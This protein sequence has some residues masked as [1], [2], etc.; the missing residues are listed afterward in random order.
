MIQI[1][2]NH[3][4]HLF[5]YL[6]FYLYFY[7][8][9]RSLNIILLNFFKIEKM[10]ENILFIKSSIFYPILG[11]FFTGNLLILIN[12]FIP[13]KSFIVVILLI[14]TLIPNI[15]RFEKN[16]FSVSIENFIMYLIIPFILIM[17]LYNTG[18][19]YDAGFYHLNHQNWL[20][21][22]Q[23]VI[24]FINVHWA[25][26]MSSIYE[27]LSSILWFDISFKYLHFLN[28]LFIH[29]FYISLF[30][31]I[32]YSKEKILKNGAFFLLLFSLLDNI[33]MN[34][35]RNGFIYI[36][37]VTKQD[38]TVAILFLVTVRA[39]FIYLNKKEINKLDF[40]ILCMISLFV[41][42][43][44]LSSVSLVI[45]IL[46]LMFITLKN[47]LLKTS[48]LIK[49]TTP[50]LIFSS[51]WIIKQFLTTGCFI[52][53]VNMTCLNNF[54]WYEVGSTAEYESI[55]RGSSYSLPYY[56]F[57][58]IGWS[59]YFF[60]FEINKTVFTNFALSILLLS[61]FFIFLANKNKDITVLPM[62]FFI[63][64]NVIYLINYGPTPRYTMGTFLIIISIF[65][66]LTKD[67]K[68]N[69]SKTL[70]YLLILIS[71]SSL[72]R[73]SSYSSFINQDYSGGLFD[74]RPDSTYFEQRNGYLKP[75]EGDQ[76][77]I[78]ID[79]TM[80]TH[81]INVDKESYFP[82]AERK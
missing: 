68:F 82:T 62:L 43:I 53:P 58:L 19:H 35:G 33:G 2:S 36:Q 70:I 75:T 38:T 37:G 4:F 12:F 81:Q 76:C 32:V 15:T 13:L 22:S 41:I 20:R 23:M 66:F 21:E 31:H 77:W 3:I 64:F 72:V 28:I 6:I 65:G 47:K 79:C 25:F 60:S 14:S 71:V 42:Q 17:S 78:N 34:G 56:D 51:I 46:L 49:Y 44:K 80:S 24:G 30:S 10:P 50:G 27:Y 11:T 26:G 59:K 61:L 74:P 69:M 55:T 45:L 9:G 54:K 48:D 63:I 1:L 40:S 18:W 57:N 8:S 73:L 39:I 67:L 5:G 16:T 52:Y 29:F 7:L